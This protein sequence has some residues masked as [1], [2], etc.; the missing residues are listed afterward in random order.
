[1]EPAAT[2]RPAPALTALVGVFL[3]LGCT[4]FGGPVAHLAYLR[5]E[6]VV[7]RRW[8]GEGEY[9]DL[10]ALCQFLPGPASSQVVFGIGLRKRG[11]PGAIA[12]S[13]GFLAPSAALMLLFAGLFDRLGSPGAAGWV[14]GLKL[15]AVAVVAQAVW[16]M[17]RK[18][19]P[20]L[21][22]AAIALATAAVLGLVASPFAQMAVIAVGAL[23]GRRWLAGGIRAEAPSH[24]GSPPGSLAWLA[25]FGALLLLSFAGPSA[26]EW[27]G[28]LAAFYRAGA[29]VF[30]GG[31]VVLPLLESEIVGPGW[32]PRD[33]FLA[34]YGAA[35]ALPG[36]LFSFA[37]FLGAAM[38]SPAPQALGTA[39]LLALM[40]PGWLLVAGVWPR[41][42]R[43]R[44]RPGA[45]GA[46]AGANAAVVGVLLAAL[47]GPVAQAGLRSAID[48]LLAIGGAVLLGRFRTPSWAVVVAFALIGQFRT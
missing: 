36:P 21:P 26:G 12:A 39:T 10:V 8:L 35:Q 32:V 18:L 29:M 2:G 41:W 3:R 42:E 47:L 11:W 28:R 16:A 30:G 15:A 37:A 33:A 44:A 9:A 13:A 31:H 6:F 48:P 45:Q 1:M 25:L 43:L 34:G 20:D 23:A 27:A 38:D 22:R 40:L 4:S 24:S 5:E 7:R 17:A 14:S 46:L 19:A